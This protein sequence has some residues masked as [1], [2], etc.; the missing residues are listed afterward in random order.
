MDNCYIYQCYDAGV[1]HQCGSNGNNV[2]MQ[3]VEYT[4]NLIT[5]CVYSIEYFLGASTG[6]GTQHLGRNILIENNIL[7]RA[8]FGFGSGR[9]DADNQ[10]H[11]RSGTHANNFENFVIK[12]N[13]FDRAVFELF[14]GCTN[15]A[16]HIPVYDSNV[17]IQ[18]F[19]NRLCSFGLG[20]GK[21]IRYNNNVIRDIVNTVGD[22]NAQVY[23][24]DT[25]PKWTY[26]TELE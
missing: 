3:K 13:V 12:N 5:D 21:I 1:T 26:E 10:R 20:S 14:Q 8:G 2:L 6:Q 25:I 15:N 16:S 22:K 4:N 19:N 11:I 7:R 17:Y 23:Y 18:G 9:P 24:V